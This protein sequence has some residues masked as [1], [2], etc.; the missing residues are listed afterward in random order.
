M[1]ISKKIISSI[2]ALVMMLA[3]VG[4]G[5]VVDGPGMELQEEQGYNN[6]V[7][8]LNVG[9]A[10]CSLIES[11]GEF[12]LLDA[13][14]ADGSTD[15]VTYLQDRGVEKISLFVLTHFHSDHTSEVLDV[16][17]NFKVDTLLIPD[18]S[19]EN[20]PTNSFYKALIEKAEK[21]QYKLALAQADKQFTVGD[22]TVTVLADT[23]NQRKAADEGKNTSQ[24]INNTSIALTITHPT[25]YGTFTMLD[26][27]DCEI[28]VE[29]Q[30]LDKVPRNVDFF[31]AGH[32]G[33][34]DANSKEF[35][36][37]INPNILVISCGKDNDYGHPHKQ[38]IKRIEDLRITYVITYEYGNVVYSM[39][40]NRLLGELD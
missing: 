5:S 17:R 11:E 12:I 18:L 16:L 40:E 30:L 34:K 7:T 25:S 21:G 32:H 15:I 20:T 8:V 28:D 13:G 29:R 26:T 9:Q 2:A 1:K 22:T 35:L 38:T 39:D 4:C 36:E 14:F 3:L 31:N 27:G 10:Q 6:T 19:E 23:Y 24:R 33:S 37:K